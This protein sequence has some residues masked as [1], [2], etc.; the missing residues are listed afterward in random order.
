MFQKVSESFGKFRKV[1]ESFGK[2]QKVLESVGKFLKALESFGKFWKV[3]ESFGKFWKFW[4]VLESFGK[5]WKVLEH[6]GKFWKVSER[7]S[8]NYIHKLIQKKLNVKKWHTL[9]GG[10]WK[11]SQNTL[12]PNIMSENIFYG[13][14][15][16]LYLFRF[17][18]NLQNW[19]EQI[20]DLAL[21]V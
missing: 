18:V 10:E 17:G 5:F 9:L 7:P 19:D 16:H 21:F 1:S 13:L 8:T 20:W 2:F 14:K 3:L 4:K 6:F 12:S 11:S 15:H